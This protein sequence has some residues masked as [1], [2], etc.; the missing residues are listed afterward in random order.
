[1]KVTSTTKDYPPADPNGTHL[2][3]EQMTDF[4]LFSLIPWVSTTN[5]NERY[6][7]PPADTV[8]G[9]TT[10]YPIANGIHGRLAESHDPSNDLPS[11][12]ESTIQIGADGAPPPPID[13]VDIGI[14]PEEVARAALEGGPPPRSPQDLNLS[15]DDK[16]RS[17]EMDIE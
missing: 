9:S 2:M 12:G 4:P 6:P 1:L 13:A 10:L 7:S 14:V 3:S 11:V 8:T 5:P 16:D 17:A 15:I